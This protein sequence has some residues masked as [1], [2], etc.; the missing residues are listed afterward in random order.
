[1]RQ[2]ALNTVFELA[3]EN[4]KIVFIGSD[5]GANTLAEMQQTLPNQFFMEGI[6]EQHLIGFA[7]G[8]AKAGFIPYVNTIANFFSRRALEQIILDM[9]LHKLPV[10]LLASGG[11]M[12]YAPLGPTHTATDDLAHMLSIPNLN[13]FAPADANEMRDI[14]RHVSK[15]DS[16]CYIRFGKGGEAIVPGLV[17]PNNPFSFKVFGKTT[18]QSIILTTGVTLQESLKAQILLE[19]QGIDVLVIHFPKLNLEAF[20]EL[21]QFTDG[22]STILVVEEHQARGG[23][24][25]QFLH[26]GFKSAFTVKELKHISLES[27]FIRKYGSQSDHLKNFG[28]TAE[29]IAN[30]L[31]G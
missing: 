21:R 28:F 20:S 24:L 13:V 2:A 1:L 6:S 22:K 29:N 27:S 5:L 12:V 3:K 10:K 18:S 14:V 30:Q 31:L 19:A 17:Q 11:G 16:P 8:L 15:D 7:S 9:S 26:T 25:T 4:S 23:L